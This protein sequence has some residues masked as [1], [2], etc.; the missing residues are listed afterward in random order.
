VRRA[1][2]ESGVQS[3]TPY[4]L[5]LGGRDELPH[6]HDLAARLVLVPC[7][8]SLGQRQIGRIGKALQD[9]SA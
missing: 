3:E 2:Y 5:L 4:P 6:A 9:L 1:L 7:H 8:A